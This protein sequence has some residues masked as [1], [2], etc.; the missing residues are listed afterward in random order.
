MKLRVLTVASVMAL[1]LTAQSYATQPKTDNEKLSYTLGYQ[2]GNGF[3]QQGMDL[4]ADMVRQ[5]LQDGLTSKTPVLTKQ[6]QQAVITKMQKQAMEK[7]EAKQKVEAEKNEKL[8][9]AF[10]K[11]NAEKSGVKT[12]KS[13]LQYKVLTAGKGAKP[14]A[15]DMVKV[16]YE[17]HLL[18]EAGNG[19]GKMFDASSK[20]GG[21]ATFAVNQVI[22]GWTEA[23]E[24]MPVGSE[25]EVYIPSKLGYGKGGIPGVIPAGSTLI[26]KVKL[27]SIEKSASEK[28]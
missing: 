3:K 1:T 10:L 2:M 28:K 26:F 18:N 19:I 16:S 6:E 13:G 14:K 21:T 22:P 4:N 25:W 12:T 15:S 7:A 8:G 11:A 27:L 17:G 20:H 23:L 9:D 5:G 24:M